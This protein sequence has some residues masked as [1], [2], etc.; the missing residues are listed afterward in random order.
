VEHPHNEDHTETDPV[1]PWD[2]FAARLGSVKDRFRKA[3][4]A[5]SDGQ[6]PSQDEI[7]SAF[8]VLGDMWSSVAGSVSS[9]LRDET[10]R[11]DLAGTA[12]SL[13]SAIGATLSQL[14]TEIRRGAVNE[15][16]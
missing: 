5:S 2:E 6:G 4:E 7:R 10:T 16:E 8:A 15:E 13:A 14:G 12:G 11:R 9:A 1:D 3:Y